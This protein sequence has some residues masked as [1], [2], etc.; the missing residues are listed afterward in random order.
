MLLHVIADTLGS[1]GV[2][3][4]S[5]LI[6]LYG[7]MIADP[8]CSLFISIMIFGSFV[9]LTVFFFLATAHPF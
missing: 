2:I 9:A 1:V 5:I 7:W 4:S 3:V 6:H 8:V